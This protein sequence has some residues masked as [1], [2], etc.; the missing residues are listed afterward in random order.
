MAVKD[1]KNPARYVACIM[2]DGYGFSADY[3]VADKCCGQPSVLTG[4]GWKIIRIWSCEWY[5]DPE[6]VLQKV[7][8][9]LE[10]ITGSRS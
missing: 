1:P 10:D 5:R 8:K 3:A 2:S 7:L 6:T 9:Q 4:L